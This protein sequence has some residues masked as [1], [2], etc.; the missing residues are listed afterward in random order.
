L[1]TPSCLTA[2]VLIGVLGMSAVMFAWWSVWAG[3]VMMMNV[4]GVFSIS[5]TTS[6]DDDADDWNERRK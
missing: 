6:Y 2:A 1:A 5:G 3:E 4:G